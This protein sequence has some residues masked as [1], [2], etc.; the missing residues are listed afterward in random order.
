[1][2]LRAHRRSAALILTLLLALMIPVAG[3][4]YETS[5]TSPLRYVVAVVPLIAVPVAVWLRSIRGRVLWSAVAAVILLISVQMAIAYNLH[6]DKTITQTL[7]SGISGWDPSFLFPLL[8]RSQQAGFDARSLAVWELVSVAAVA[9]GFWWG[10]K[11][12]N[13]DVRSARIQA[14]AMATAFAV[15]P[16]AG[17]LAIAAGGPKR[18]LRL[19]KTPE[20]S[21]RECRAACTERPPAFQIGAIPLE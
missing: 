17:W 11:R 7:A 21:S 18:E 1:M 13:N 14:A 15:I 9:G 20:Q 12:T 2:M 19:L 8:R 6:N 16:L 4:G 5:G 3:R 10:S